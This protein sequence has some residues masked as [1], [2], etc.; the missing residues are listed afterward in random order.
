MKS[1][2]YIFYFV[3]GLTTL[4]LGLALVG[5]YNFFFGTVS[6]IEN[7]NGCT[8]RKVEKVTEVNQPKPIKFDIND[9]E[10]VLPI[11]YEEEKLTSPK[12]DENNPEYFDPE[13]KYFVLDDSGNELGDL[14]FIRIENK[15]FEVGAKDE[16]F[17]APIN[18]KGSL[19]V[20]EENQYELEKINISDGKLQTETITKDGIKYE[21]TGE[22]VVKG[23][24]YTLDENARVLKGTLTKKR[25]G[26]VISKDDVT[27]G[28]TLE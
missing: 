11:D 9:P 21:F 20:N 4:F 5:I 10:S 18:P 8:A 23:N 28:W 13:G 12:V 26:E 17:G 15:N 6:T 27:F 16:R 25:N 19:A 22:F 7:T 14:S 3:I 24:F 2:N 1:R